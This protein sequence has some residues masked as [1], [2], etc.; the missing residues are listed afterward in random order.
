MNPKSP[1]QTVL[2]AMSGGVDSSVT[3]MLLKDQGYS[4]IGVHLQLWNQGE[5]NLE[6]IGGRCCSLTDAQDARRVCDRLEIPFYILNAQDIFREKVVD[7]FVHDYLQ[8]RTPNPCAQC[9]IDIKFNYLFQKADELGC[10][11]VATGHYARVF[12]DQVRG[13]AHLQKAVDAQKDQTYF[14]FGLTQKALI[15]TLLPLGGFHKK[16]VRQ[17]AEE[18]DLA[19]SKKPDSQEICFI[20]QEGYQK[21]IEDQVAPELRPGGFI[22]TLD[23]QLVGQHQGLFR[24][25]IG[26]RKGLQLQMKDPEN[27]FVVGADIKTRTLFVGPEAQLFHKGLFATQVNWIQSPDFLKGVVCRAKIRSRHEEAE[28]RVTPFEEA[29]V[30]VEFREPQRAITPGQAIVF[31]DGEEVLGGGFIEEVKDFPFSEALEAHTTSSEKPT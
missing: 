14:L 31:Y 30:W 3:A 21:F 7:Y 6:E 15:R 18:Y 29:R 20:A 22:R 9:N 13:R 25:T 28:C 12:H 26:Q 11:W 23:G 2:V 8:N 17:L 24:Y 4:V 10:H 1:T 19:V 16:R 27:Y 5:Q